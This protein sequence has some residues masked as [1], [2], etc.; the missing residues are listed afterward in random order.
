MRTKNSGKNIIF[1]ISTLIITALLGFVLSKVFLSNLGLEYNGLNGVFNNIINILAITELG[2]AGAINYNLYKPIAEKDY[3]KISSIMVIYKKFYKIIGITIFS[4]A[5]IVAFFVPVFFKER[6]LLDSYIRVTFILCALNTVISYFFAYNRNLFYAMQK[7][8]ITTIV[9]FIFKIS[10]YLLQIAIL[11]IFKN[12]IIYLAINIIFTL[13]NNLTIHLM[14]KKYYK[15]INI[16][17]RKADKKIEKTILKSVKNLAIIQLLSTLINF[18]DNLIISSLIS[19]I[20]SGL[21]VNYNQIF[22]QLTQ[23]VN[24]IFHGFGASIGNLL[25]EENKEKIKKIFI[26]LQYLSFFIGL[27]CVVC[28]FFLTQPFIE[29]W[30]GKEYLLNISILLVLIT[31]FYLMI[32]RQPINY[33]LNTGGYFKKLILPFGLETIINI[34]TSIILALKFG[35]IGVF[36]GTLISSIISFIISSKSLCKTIELKFLKYWQ[37]E[38]LFLIIILTNL[39]MFYLI[40]NIYTPENLILKLAYILVI[41]T[42]IISIE[43]IIFIKKDSNITRLK[44]IYESILNKIFN[45]IKKIFLS[46]RKVERNT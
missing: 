36:I 33:Y 32:Q 6:T 7:N 25:A 1:G 11:I 40:F 21:Y 27:Y 28:L 18:T 20:Y 19:V 2:I 10:K 34:I 35:L 46:H 17:N 3:E 38:F 9:D 45:K 30:I 42:I 24:T 5:V 15:N 14:A 37:K 39:V 44:E 29:L 26:N 41:I 16:K 43:I 13:L 4:L 8:Y 31:N 12:F 22:T 23:I